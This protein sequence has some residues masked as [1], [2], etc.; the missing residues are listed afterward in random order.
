MGVHHNKL[1]VSEGYRAI[2]K[3]LKLSPFSAKIL[4]LKPLYTTG[5]F[6]EVAV[7]FFKIRPTVEYDM[8]SIISSST[9][10]SAK[11]LKDHCEYPFGASLQAKA[12]TFARTCPS[13]LTGRPRPKTPIF[14][15]YSYL[16]ILKLFG[17]LL[18]ISY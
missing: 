12:V 17:N 15:P 7:R 4:L 2:D 16:P 3:A 18:I 10:R 11:S 13:N 5:V 1:L 9:K 6:Y 8:S 14:S